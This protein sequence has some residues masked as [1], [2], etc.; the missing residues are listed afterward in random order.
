MNSHVAF[1]A[2]LSDSLLPN[3]QGASDKGI[4]V[5]IRQ[6]SSAIGFSTIAGMPAS[7][8]SSPFAT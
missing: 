1:P 7:I 3:Q 5:T 2:R 8:A 4:Q 6:A